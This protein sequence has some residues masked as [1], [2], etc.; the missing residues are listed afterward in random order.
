PRT[1]GGRGNQKSSSLYS[2][3]MENA[4]S[5]APPDEKE[6]AQGGTTLEASSAIESVPASVSVSPP[7][8]A[9]SSHPI[10]LNGRIFKKNLVTGGTV[11]GVTGWMIE[12]VPEEEDITVPQ[13]RISIHVSS[14]SNDSPLA[15]ARAIAK[16]H[17]RAARADRKVGIAKAAPYEEDLWSRDFWIKAP[18]KNPEIWSARDGSAWLELS[19][20][21]FADRRAEFIRMRIGRFRGWELLVEHQLRSDKLGLRALRALSDQGLLERISEE[22]FVNMLIGPLPGTGTR[23]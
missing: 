7:D 3:N 8:E 18:Y 17:T 4:S 11:L 19:R 21:G 5:S 6:E 1:T 22:A 16:S 13:Q 14:M 10:I 9:S 23:Q 15:A 12:L 20:Y 2:D